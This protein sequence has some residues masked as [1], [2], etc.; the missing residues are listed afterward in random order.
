MGFLPPP[1]LFS[2]VHAGIAVE[3]DQMSLIGPDPVGIVG[4][5]G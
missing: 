4:P 3:D 1:D 5:R 2:P